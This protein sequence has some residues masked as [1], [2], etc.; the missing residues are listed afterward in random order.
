LVSLWFSIL[1]L[2]QG[3]GFGINETLYLLLVSSELGFSDLW[4]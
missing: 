1:R 3:K 2:V 4:V